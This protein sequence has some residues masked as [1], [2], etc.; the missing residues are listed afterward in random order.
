MAKNYGP[1]VSQYLDP[2]GYAWETVVHQSGRPL[3]DAELNLGEDL[4]DEDRYSLIRNSTPS[5]WVKATLYQNDDRLGGDF[6][7]GLTIN[8]IALINR[9]V[10]YVNGWH[11]PVEYTNVSFAGANLIQFNPPPAT[12][13]GT[14][15]VDLAFLEVWR[16]LIPPNPGITNKPSATQIY[17][18]GN[19]LSLAP[20]WLADD[21]IDPTLGAES[22]KRV[23][24]QYRIRVVDG[25]DPFTYAEG[26]DDPSV[27][28]FGASGAPTGFLWTNQAANGDSGLWR[29]GDGNPLNTLTT[30]DGYS[31]AIPIMF[32][33]RRNT[34]AWNRLTN[35]NGGVASPGPSDRPDGQ[36][37]DILTAND[38]LDLRHLVSPKG[39]DWQEITERNL[40]MLL[41]RRLQTRSIWTAGIYDTGVGTGG[42]PFTN[43]D[44]IGV[45][46]GDGVTTGD[47]PGGNFI[48]QFD[49]VRRRYS[50]KPVVQRKY[51][52][53]NPPG[54]NWVPADTLVFD[55]ATDLVTGG[56]PFLAHMPAGTVITDVLL[57]EH[58]DDLGTPR[59]APD[60]ASITGLGTTLV[61]ITL[62]AAVIPST[63]DIWVEYELSYPSGNGMASSPLNLA[64]NFS[65][66]QNNPGSLP[67]DFAAFD[68]AGPAWIE[69]NREIE[70]LYETIDIVETVMPLTPN[71]LRVTHRVNT[72]TSVVQGG[73]IA[74]AP[75]TRDAPD[76]LITTAAPMVLG[77][78]ATVTY[79]ALKPMCQTGFQ[80]TVYYQSQ[81]PQTVQESLLPATL[82][83]RFLWMSP[84][85]YTG[86]AGTATYDEPYPWTVP[87]D[88]IPVNADEPTYNGGGGGEHLMGGAIQISVDDFD[89]DTG[90][91]KLH[92]M[93]PMP[94]L[95]KV[96]LS[97][98]DTDV[99][100]RSHYK[101]ATDSSGY[102]P[103]M[104][105]QGI[106]TPQAHKVFGYG[107]VQTL[108][109]SPLGPPGSVLLAILS[110]YRNFDDA[111]EFAFTGTNTS[112]A[113]SL[114][115]T[116]GNIL[117][118]PE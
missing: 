1:L 50:D 112:T 86:T 95:G 88:P 79:S 48:G 105:A 55:L 78:P 17:R 23:Q 117:A 85:L 18:N 81:A 59:P 51:R 111:S 57:M 115:K 113:I 72:V 37:Y 118:L 91:L 97:D 80:L 89:A 94:V 65:F 43:A 107:L 69:H 104:A 16:A 109:D 53:F 101:D 114:V 93:V 15:R 45:L 61:T 19:V 67:L 110:E 20:E 60:V 13:P 38:I 30:V 26:L 34:D 64:G 31:Y 46:P 92:G 5:G 56:T 62:G 75:V 44:E 32:V 58:D 103:M 9:P 47:T 14:Y 41:D 116:R 35:G 8:D 102:K 24:I 6:S 76:Q 87:L 4:D 70:V 28:A 108:E 66:F 2:A 39:W 10:A 22:T 99:E 82:D 11:I 68:T 90:L 21:L 73:P 77:V 52:T 54:A 25:V 106:S 40:N 33:H 49:E 12:G 71:H 98:K 84:N 96:T 100:H 74:V 27:D 29:A 3:T 42:N 83:V 7:P 36:F 63:R